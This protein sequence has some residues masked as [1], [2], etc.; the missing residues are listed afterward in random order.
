MFMF[1]I[2][3]DKMQQYAKS[4]GGRSSVYSLV[5]ISMLLSHRTYRRNWITMQYVNVI[6][7]N[8]CSAMVSFL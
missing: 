3:D 4:R 6:Y 7:V 1:I 2:I 8:C 5:S